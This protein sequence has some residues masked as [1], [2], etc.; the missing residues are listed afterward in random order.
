SFIGCQN[1]A[2]AFAS[3]S[4]C[5]DTASLAEKECC[6]YT[7][8]FDD[9][10]FLENLEKRALLPEPIP[11]LG[12]VGVA[13]AAIAARLRADETVPIYI[14]GLDFSYSVGRTHARGTA[15]A[16]KALAELNRLN[17]PGAYAA[18]FGSGARPAGTDAVTTVALS[19]YADIFQRFFSETENIFDFRNCGL[20]LGAPKKTEEEAA[21]AVSRAAKSSETAGAGG[22]IQSAVPPAHGA[23]HAAWNAEQAGQISDYL[24]EERAALLQ[25]QDILSGERQMEEEER[26]RRIGQLLECRD[27]LHLH[28][29]DGIRPSLDPG[30]LKRVRAEAGFFLKTI[31]T[32]LRRLAEL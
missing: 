2:V 13:A 7:T 19:G 8:R 15:P 1:A 25:L 9:A 31:E 21:E 27:Y 22:T 5:P 14:S 26:R 28:F 12:S 23:K 24:A 18:A 10:S 11:P 3:L 16:R 32:S 6:F 30:F 20:P 17:P 29:P 4:S